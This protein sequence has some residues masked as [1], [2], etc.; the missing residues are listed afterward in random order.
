[1]ITEKPEIISTIDP[2]IQVF[3]WKTIKTISISF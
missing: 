1:L 2:R 3:T